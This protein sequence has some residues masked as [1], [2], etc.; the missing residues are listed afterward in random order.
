[1]VTKEQ[2]KLYLKRNEQYDRTESQKGETL[3]LTIV[4]GYNNFKVMK[5]RNQIYDNKA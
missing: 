4:K 1:M 3:S 5:G 2:H